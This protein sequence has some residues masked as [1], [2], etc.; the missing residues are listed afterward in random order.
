MNWSTV[1]GDLRI[2]HFVGL[3]ALQAL[4]LVG[5]WFGRRAVFAAALAWTMVTVALAALA[6]MVRPLYWV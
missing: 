1:V 5:A 4:P 2:A 6:A 3:H